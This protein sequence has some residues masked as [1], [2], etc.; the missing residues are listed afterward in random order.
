MIRVISLTSMLKQQ[1]LIS[2]PFETSLNIYKIII[3]KVC[4][5]AKT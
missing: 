5:K 2:I 4:L 1:N 3:A